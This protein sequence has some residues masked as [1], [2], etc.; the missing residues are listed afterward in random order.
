MTAGRWQEVGIRK[1]KELGLKVLGIDSNPEA[2]GLALCDEVMIC[3]FN[4]FE[5]IL[6]E[7]ELLKID[8]VG[9]VSTCSEAGMPLAAE[10]REKFNLPGPGKEM[11]SRLMRKE[12]QRQVWA[13]ANVPGPKWR[14]CQT[15]SDVRQACTEI[16][17]P[18]IMKPTDSSGSRGVAKVASEGEVE[19]AFHKALGFSGSQKVLV[20]SFMDGVEFAIESLVVKGEVYILAVSEKKKVEGT[21]ETVASEYI[22]PQC[23]LESLERI[24][25]VVT[26]AYVAIGYQNGVGH[27]EVILEESG[28]VGLVEVAGRGGGFTVFETYVPELTGVDFP[29]LATQLALGHEV[30]LEEVVQKPAVL[31]FFPS[32][33]GV[34]T[35]I[36]GLEDARA[37]PG[38]IVDTFVKIGD[39]VGGA[40]ADGDRLGFVLATALSY[41]EARATVDKISSEI[42]FKIEKKDSSCGR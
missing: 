37:K 1:A 20:E 29:L 31:K 26:E 24:K 40:K 33:E 4:N 19:E 34:V 3:S 15:L 22:A 5:E 8:L 7:I 2:S 12:I 42:T 38:V 28:F 35:D 23:S 6:R 32:Q 41:A 39:V 10:I 16:G 9:V 21:R 13:Q 11:T 27:A 17:Y 14:V 25:K 18:L 36:Q 30:S